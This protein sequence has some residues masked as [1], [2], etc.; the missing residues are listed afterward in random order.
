MYTVVHELGHA[1]GLYHEQARPDRDEYVAIRNDNIL[2]GKTHNFRIETNSLTYG[3][4]YDYLSVMHY[5]RNVSSTIITH[6]QCSLIRT[7]MF[8]I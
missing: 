7:S 3:V 1:V 6:A 4:L 8:R 2:D 5:S